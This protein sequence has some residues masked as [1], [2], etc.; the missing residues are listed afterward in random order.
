MKTQMQIVE[1]AIAGLESMSKEEFRAS[2]IK[3]GKDEVSK[4]LDLFAE[5]ITLSGTPEQK[6]EQLMQMFNSISLNN[7]SE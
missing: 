6:A 4:T 1:E 3:A 7:D 5:T 2:L